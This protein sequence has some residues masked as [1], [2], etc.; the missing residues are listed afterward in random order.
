MLLLQAVC[1]RKQDS[2]KLQG[3]LV[4]FRD[5]KTNI[6]PDSKSTNLRESA[7]KNKYETE[8]YITI[9]AYSY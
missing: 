9:L 1:D 6:N 7:A 4:I 3:Y 5:Y 2:C 8:L